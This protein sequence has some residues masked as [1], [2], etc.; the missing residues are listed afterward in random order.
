MAIWPMGPLMHMSI[1]YELATPILMIEGHYSSTAPTALQE[2]QIMMEKTQ[3]TLCATQPQ[4][5]QPH[6]LLEL[7][8]HKTLDIK[9]KHL[10]PSP[11]YE[12]DRDWH[13]DNG[14]T[15]TVYGVQQ[16][17]NDQR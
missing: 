7:L 3:R 6:P 10:T 17:R 12:F 11:R 2:P 5:A 4:K 13:D 1:M 15:Y 14:N 16:F 9:I 8:P